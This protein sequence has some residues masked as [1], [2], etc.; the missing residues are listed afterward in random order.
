MS[1]VCF[2]SLKNC[3]LVLVVEGCHPRPVKQIY[4]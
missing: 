4:L 2:S 1:G 3:M